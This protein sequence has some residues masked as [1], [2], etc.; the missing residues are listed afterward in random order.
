[1]RVE[2]ERERKDPMHIHCYE[3][4]GSLLYSTMGRP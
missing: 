4:Q 1:M 3:E 2:R